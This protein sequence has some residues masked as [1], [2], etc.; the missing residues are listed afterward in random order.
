ML[1]GCPMIDHP[2]WDTKTHPFTSKLWMY[3]SAPSGAVRCQ[4]SPAAAETQR[5]GEP[6]GEPLCHMRSAAWP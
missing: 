2:F 6:P 4:R 5:G 1:I 3:R